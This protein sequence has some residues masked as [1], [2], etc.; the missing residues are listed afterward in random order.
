M[1]N[2]YMKR[3]MI[4]QNVCMSCHQEFES[5]SSII[6]SD[7][8]PPAVY[9]YCD[10]PYCV[11]QSKKWINSVYDHYHYFLLP[12]EIDFLNTPN[13]LVYTFIGYFNPA[14]L[15]MG[16]WHTGSDNSF[17]NCALSRIMGCNT[18]LSKIILNNS[19]HTSHISPNTINILKKCLANE[20]RKFLLLQN[21]V[22]QWRQYTLYK[23]TY[24]QMLQY[25]VADV[26]FSP[27]G[28]GNQRI[29]R[30]YL[31]INKK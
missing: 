5:L 14:T 19:I 9:L 20:E 7:Q 1:A 26:W 18:D 30:H 24:R 12:K 31:E 4:F 2:I 22:K 23:K 17:I 28:K 10:N 11:Q 3:V 6:V 8:L 25:Y 21:A 27:N 13:G 15:A 16:I 29:M